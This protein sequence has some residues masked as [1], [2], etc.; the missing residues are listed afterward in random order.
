MGRRGKAPKRERER[1]DESWEEVGSRKVKKE[2][3]CF[4]VGE[5]D[6]IGEEVDRM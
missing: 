2:E 6:D 4:L 1:D 3:S 5:V